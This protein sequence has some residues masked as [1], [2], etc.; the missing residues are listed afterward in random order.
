MANPKNKVLKFYK[1]LPFNAYSSHDQMI[2]AIKN[3]N[4]LLLYPQLNKIIDKFNRI[5]VLD[6]GC[7]C[8]WFINSLNYYNNKVDCTGVDFNSKAVK[9]AN[10]VKDKLRLSNNF[11]TKDLFKVNFKIKF[12]LITSIGVLHHT[13]NLPLAIK[14]IS[15]LLKKDSYLFLGLYHKYGRKPFLDYFKNMKNKT[16]EY[17]FSKYKEL[18]KT[19]LKDDVHIYS[20]FRDQVLHPH[21][22]QHTFYEISK[23]LI[24]EGF[25]INS[26]SI[27][28]FKKIKN[29]KH[30]YDEE[31]KYSDI[32]EKKLKS[33]QYFPGFFI[34]IAKKK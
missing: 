23:L 13:E 31:K 10:S 24:K 32:A 33:F 21:E 20:W 30:I 5:K 9:F 8:G 22:T 34:I 12:D 16:D 4:P 29:L 3:Q 11:I 28:K 2:R 14:K 26:T 6:I 1:E 7:G 17:K 18:H 19:Y 27:N 25:E 15:Q